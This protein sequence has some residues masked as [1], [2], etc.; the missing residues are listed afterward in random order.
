MTDRPM[1]KDAKGGRYFLA[2]AAEFTGG[3]QL[4]KAQTTK[5]RL[6]RPFVPD[7]ARLP[8]GR[9]AHAFVTT[10]SA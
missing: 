9:L 2:A 7:H 8:T 1:R 6:R 5:E 10:I 4:G 3:A